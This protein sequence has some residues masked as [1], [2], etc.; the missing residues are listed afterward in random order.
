[1]SAAVSLVKVL[2]A[3]SYL[4]L[5]NPMDCSPP[6]SSVRGISQVRIL[7]WVAISFSSDLPDPGVELTSLVSLHLQVDSF[8]L[9]HMFNRSQADSNRSAYSQED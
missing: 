8:L 1:M 6:G 2:L 4:I 5:C 7:E 3:H 9:P